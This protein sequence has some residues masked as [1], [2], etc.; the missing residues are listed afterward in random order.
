M[1]LHFVNAT[2]FVFPTEIGI[3]FD[4]VYLLLVRDASEHPARP[5]VHGML[6][7]PTLSRQWV[8]RRLQRALSVERWGAPLRSGLSRVGGAPGD[9]LRG[10]GETAANRARILEDLIREIGSEP[11]GSWGIGAKVTRAAASLVGHS[12]SAATR[13]IALLMAEHTMSEYRALEAV[14]Q[15]SPGVSFDLLTTVTPLRDESAREFAELADAPGSGA[16]SSASSTGRN[17]ESS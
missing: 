10:H 9:T 4:R 12:S 8:A 13:R 1:T 14:V 16:R 17:D 2:S 3:Y 7:E 6:D 5:S 11:Y 15:E